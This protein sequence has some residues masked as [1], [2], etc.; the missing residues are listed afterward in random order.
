MSQAGDEAF[1]YSITSL[2]IGN[3]EHSIAEIYVEVFASGHGCDEFYYSNVPT[4]EAES[5]GICGGGTY[6]EV[7]GMPSIFLSLVGFKLAN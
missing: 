1:V 6:R 5:L 3:P 4:E 7:Q 2:D